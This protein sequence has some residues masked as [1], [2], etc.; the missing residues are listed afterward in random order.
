MPQKPCVCFEHRDYCN[1]DPA[2]ESWYEPPVANAPG[3]VSR[4]YRAA[5]E[6]IRRAARFVLAIIKGFRTLAA[7]GLFMLAGLADQY[8]FVDVISW[9]RALMG[10]SAKVGVV[11]FAVAAVFFL[12]RIASPRK[13]DDAAPPA[14]LGKRGIDEGE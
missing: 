2:N 13:H 12:L 8:D 3:F 9:I 6:A 7:A 5:P 11:I 10:E 4:A 14:P 1:C